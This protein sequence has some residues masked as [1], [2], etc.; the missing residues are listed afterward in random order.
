MTGRGR[1]ASATK[2]ALAVPEH[3]EVR[4]GALDDLEDRPASS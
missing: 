3:F 4:V 1:R 2:Q